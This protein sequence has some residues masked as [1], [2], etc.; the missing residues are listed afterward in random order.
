MSSELLELAYGFASGVGSQPES[1]RLR[2][3]IEALIPLQGSRMPTVR[4]LG[5]KLAHFRRRPIDGLYLDQ[6]PGNDRR[7]TVWHVAAVPERVETGG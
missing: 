3:A 5:K 2:T 4:Q 7:G 6:S 1:V